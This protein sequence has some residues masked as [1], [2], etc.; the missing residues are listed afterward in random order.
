MTKLQH[1]AGHW[2]G[3]GSKEHPKIDYNNHGHV[4]HADFGPSS[5]VNAT[6]FHMSVFFFPEPLHCSSNAAE[7]TA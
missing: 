1:R 5:L 6:V 4:W 3:G 7:G 2:S